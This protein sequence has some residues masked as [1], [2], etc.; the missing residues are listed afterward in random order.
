MYSRKSVGPRIDL[1]EPPALTRYSCEDFPSRTTESHLL[2]I[3]EEMRPKIWREIPWDLSL[4]RRPVCQTLSKIL[5]ISSGYIKMQLSE[6]LQLIE[7]GF[8][9][10]PFPNILKYRDH[11]WDLL[12]SWKT[13]LSGTYWRDQLVCMKVQAQVL[14]NHHRNTI[15]T[16]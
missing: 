1:W 6:A 10:R 2:L 4:W 13:R 16:R 14:Y 8:S 5:D 7:I 9:C 11:R 3:K 15:T 12:T